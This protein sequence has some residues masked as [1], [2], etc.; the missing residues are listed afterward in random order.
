MGLKWLAGLFYPERWTGNLREDTA[1]FYRLWYHVEL[2][3]TGARSP[4][5]M[6]ERTSALSAGRAEGARVGTAFW[7][8]LAVIAGAFAALLIGPYPLGPVEALSILTRGSGAGEPPNQAE[9][10]LWA[11]RLPRVAAALLVGAALAAA[12][13]CYQ[14]IFRNPLVSPDILGVSAGAGLGAVLGIFLSLPVAAIQFLGLCRRARGGGPGRLRRRR[15]ALPGT[16]PSSS[17]SPASWWGR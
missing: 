15:G 1:A 2:G 6:G 10:V 17:C 11:I 7:L 5:G 13:A 3:E 8:V 16:G 14:T 12:G 9:T 4:A